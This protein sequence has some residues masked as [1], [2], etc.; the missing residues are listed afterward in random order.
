MSG[1][2]PAYG[3]ALWRR[4]RIGDR[5]RVAYLLV[6][7]YWRAPKWMPGEIPRLAVKTAP[8]H[9]GRAERFDWRA[10]AAMTVLAIDV[11]GPDEREDGPDSWDPWLWLLADVQLYARDV[12]LFTPT[13]EFKDP[14]E[15]WAP[16][17]ILETYAWLNRRFGSIAGRWEWPPW[18][19]HGD[20]V[21][22]RKVA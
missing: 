12:I 9:D 21:C 11:R 4:R 15:A 1:R 8:W 16:E 17:R 22:Q 13:I 18:W 3:N 10:V 14:P 19:P 5:P 6:G 2:F 20:V 7:N